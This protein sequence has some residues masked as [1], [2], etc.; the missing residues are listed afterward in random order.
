MNRDTHL[1][2]LQD[3]T[4]DV[5]VIGGGAT[6]AGVALDAASRGLKTALVER[7]DFSAGTS[8]RST[9]LIHG[10]VR[11]L[12][13]AVK[14]LDRSQLNL[15]RD[16]LKERATLLKLAPHLA[17]PL[18]IL[19]PLY[20][21]FN[22]PY[23]MT[24][25]K[26]Y[27]TLAG[28]ANLA[29]SRFVG[30]KEALT[31]FP[32]L[33]REGLRGGVLYYDGQFDDARM[34]VALA[35]TAAR[36]GAAVAN[37]LEVT[38]LLK[39]GGT[40]R[41]A[42]VRDALTGETWEITAK[43]VVNA[44]GP[45]S[46]TIR[47]LDDPSAPPLLT[48]SSGSHI[49]LDR[50]FSPP[51]TGLLI[52]QT[53]D[54]RVL[55]LLPWLGYT[56]VGTTDHPA[57]IEAHPQATEDDI[58][59]I[60]R[61]LA[62]YFDLPVTRADVRAAW[63]GLRPLV[64][65]PKAADTARLSRDH[66]LNIAPSGLVTIAG[67]KWTTYRKMALDTVD[68]ALRVGGLHA[69]PSR[70]ETLKLVG[71]DGFRPDGAAGLVK[72]FGLEPDVAAY[73][74]RA[75]GDRAPEVAGLARQYPERLAPEHPHLEAEVLYSARFEGAQTA[76][77]VLARRMRLAFVDQRAALEAL[78]R[79]VQLL[80]EVFAW[81]ETKKCAEMEAAR[82]H[83]GVSAARSAPSPQAPTPPSAAP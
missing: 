69:G 41:G 2:R 32:M 19:T 58:A 77:D 22:I 7:D 35:L 15:V 73:L 9:K 55:F 33:R 40:L 74:H 38:G 50:R 21:W 13:Q 72:G 68:A 46:D 47:H 29:G 64:S 82:A 48:A 3:D 39:A 1:R 61:H 42:A 53:D 83:L 12:E 6:G 4:F 78:P 18:P 10:G 65:D 11:Y 28:R 43:V 27:D 24:G 49:V 23:M 67:G 16:A 44:T 5:L 30:P 71:A 34:N 57:P 37:H 79:V 36:E 20:T 17:H 45:F 54:G 70:T 52:P 76:T 75:Y 51:D 66:V 63:S 59:Y 8:S 56:L 31:R 81:D 62:T 25:L 60:L 14:K 80:G 26:L